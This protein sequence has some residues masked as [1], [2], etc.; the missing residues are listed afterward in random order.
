MLE[1]LPERRRSLGLST[2]WGLTAGIASF[3]EDGD[4]AEQLLAAADQRLYLQRGI[5]IEPRSD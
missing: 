4:T 1:G 5:R 2:Q 3:P